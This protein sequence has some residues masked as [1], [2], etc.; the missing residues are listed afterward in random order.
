MKFFKWGLG[1]GDWEIY[2]DDEKIAEGSCSINL[3]NQGNVTIKLI[4]LNPLATLS[5]MFFQLT[6]IISVDFSGFDSSKLIDMFQMFEGCNNLK[7]ANL[8]N[9][10]TSLV[11]SMQSMFAS[12]YSLESLDL[13][14]WNTKSV[15]NMDSIFYFVVL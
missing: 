7:Y 12:C 10:N 3:E 2:L 4:W 13:S 9:L 11:Q 5:Y 14:N 1:I 8:T 15:V 6:N